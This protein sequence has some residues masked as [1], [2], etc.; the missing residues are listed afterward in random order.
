MVEPD[1]ETW[2]LRLRLALFALFFQLLVHR[3]LLLL[4]LLPFLFQLL[5]ESLLLFALLLSPLFL[6]LLE[7]FLLLLTLLPFLF[8]LLL[9]LSQL[10]LPPLALFFLLVLDRFLLLLLLLAF[11]FLWL[12][13]LFLAH[14][15]FLLGHESHNIVPRSVHCCRRTKNKRQAPPAAVG[16]YQPQQYGYCAV[17]A[18]EFV[19]AL[20]SMS[21]SWHRKET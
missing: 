16:Y 5:L 15:V 14:F 19:L 8:Q 10:F 7:Y 12:S 20:Y 18:N 9:L 11:L 6:L 3:L 2:V 4:T 1:R 21:V 17:G 13:R